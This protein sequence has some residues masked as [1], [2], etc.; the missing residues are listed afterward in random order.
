MSALIALV[1]VGDSVL[2]AQ[3]VRTDQPK[4]VAIVLGASGGLR[5][6]NLSSYLLAPKGS[7]D[8]IALDAGTLL[9]GIVKAESLGS[10]QDIMVPSESNLTREGRILTHHIKAYLISHPHLDHLAGLIINSPDDTNKPILGLPS[11]IDNT[12]DH[13]FNGTIWPNFGNE[14]KSALKKFRYVRILPEQT[15]SIP[16]TT[17]TVEAFELSHASSPSTAF[18]IHSGGVAVLYFGDTGADETEGS[19][20]MKRVWTRV[21]PLVREQQLRGIFLEVSYPEERP[22]NQLYGHLTPSLLM[23][24]LHQLARLV[25]P[26]SPEN[27]LQNLLVMVTHMKPSFKQGQTPERQI[28]QQL[29]EL[30][31]LGIRFLTP[32]QGQRIEF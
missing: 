12:R 25:N 1:G 5:E 23:K 31:D 30:N 3:H 32:H 19:N 8:F 4:F 27:A 26:T 13:V 21:A 22:Q 29:H 24:E 16:E 28:I 11:T 6:D 14:G 7:T 2:A 15:Y 20:R 9:A 17:M 10:F 18:L